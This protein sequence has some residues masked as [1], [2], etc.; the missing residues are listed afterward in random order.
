[1]VDCFL[2]RLDFSRRFVTKELQI[3]MFEV[4]VSRIVVYNSN[5]LQLV[6]WVTRLQPYS[7]DSETSSESGSTASAAESFVFFGKELCILWRH[8]DLCNTFA[9][10][11]CGCR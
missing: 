4:A 6:L 2:I 9:V 8:D 7:C 10:P 11:L 3:K 5:N 1:M